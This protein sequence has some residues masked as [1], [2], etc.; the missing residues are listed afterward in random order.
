[1]SPAVPLRSTLDRS[2]ALITLMFSHAQYSVLLCLSLFV[3]DL[4]VRCVS[5]LVCLSVTCLRC[6]K[7]AKRIEVLFG[8]RSCSGTEGT[9]Y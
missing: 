8:Y 4:V 6:A 1:M 3:D 2:A 5:L 9:V 7:P